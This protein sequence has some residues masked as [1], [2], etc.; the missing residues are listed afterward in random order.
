MLK[1]L[2]IGNCEWFGSMISM[3]SLGSISLRFTSSGIFFCCNSKIDNCI[4]VRFLR[5]WLGSR[6]RLQKY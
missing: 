4:A 3:R 2:S 6:S 1:M 5:C